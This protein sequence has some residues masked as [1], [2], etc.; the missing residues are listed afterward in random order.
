[1]KANINNEEDEMK[2]VKERKRKKKRASDSCLE[3]SFIR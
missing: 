1:M 3:S 2:R